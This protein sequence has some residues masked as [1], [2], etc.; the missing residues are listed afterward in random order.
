MA[1][2]KDAE[3]SA[4]LS[5]DI[6]GGTKIESELSTRIPMTR[7]LRRMTTIEGSDVRYRTLAFIALAMLRA[8]S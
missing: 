5:E 1:L 2:A 8:P 3:K 4:D 7:Q 6:I